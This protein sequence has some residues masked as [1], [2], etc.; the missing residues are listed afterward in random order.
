M[1]VGM[2]NT[3]R[4]HTPKGVEFMPSPENKIISNTYY[5]NEENTSLQ[6]LT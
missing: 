6:F 1:K 4:F 5:L 3:D 2:V